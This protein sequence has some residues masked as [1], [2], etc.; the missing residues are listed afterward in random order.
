MGGLCGQSAPSMVKTEMPVTE[1]IQ[2]QLMLLLET[3]KLL[4]YMFIETHLE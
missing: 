1:H 4:F 3:V 2:C